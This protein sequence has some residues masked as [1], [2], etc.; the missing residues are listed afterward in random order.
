MAVDAHRAMQLVEHVGSDRRVVAEA[1]DAEQA[2]VGGEAD[3]LQILEIPQPAA[4]IEVI[5]VVDEC[6]VGR[7]RSSAG[8]NP[9]R[10]LSLQPVAIG[11]VEGGNDFD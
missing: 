9:A 3:L 2:S 4:D 7:R 6:A 8:A 10:Q 11:A 1:L 5:R